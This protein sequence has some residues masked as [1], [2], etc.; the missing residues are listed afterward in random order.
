MNIVPSSLLKRAININKKGP[1]SYPLPPKAPMEKSKIL[2]RRNNS[3]S[4]WNQ[5]LSLLQSENMA[6]NEDK[7]LSRR[8]NSSFHQ[9]FNRR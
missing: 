3:S 5:S 7:A 1:F 6:N 9:T 4:L 8:K 2:H